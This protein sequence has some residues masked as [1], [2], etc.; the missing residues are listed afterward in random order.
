MDDGP[1]GS[2][3]IVIAD[4][5][6]NRTNH[7]H[8]EPQSPQR[9]S[10]TTGIWTDL[11][12]GNWALAYPAWL[13]T[14]PPPARGRYPDRQGGARGAR[15]RDRRSGTTI[16]ST[17]SGSLHARGSAPPTSTRSAPVP[18]RRRTPRR[19]SGRRQ[20]ADG[21][22]GRAPGLP[23]TGPSRPSLPVGVPPACRGSNRALF[24]THERNRPMT[25]DRSYSSIAIVIVLESG[26]TI[27]LYLSREFG[28]FAAAVCFSRARTRIHSPANSPGGIRTAVQSN[29]AQR[30]V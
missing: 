13:A 23:A 30:F 12:P 3:T 16:P 24:C 19:R 2:H 17:L 20:K 22:V 10:R 1:W 21:V 26:D 5:N 4:R 7:L 18:A 8:A 14:T 9:Q 15:R 27:K 11:G 29:P 28:P 6:R 25:G